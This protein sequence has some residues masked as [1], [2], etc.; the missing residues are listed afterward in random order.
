MSETWALSLVGMA[1]P[2]IGSAAWGEVRLS[3]CQVTFCH[4]KEGRVRAVC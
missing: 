2:V 3:L 1:V 4:F